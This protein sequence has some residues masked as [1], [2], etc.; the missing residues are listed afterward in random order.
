MVWTRVV[1]EIGMGTDIR[2]T[3]YTKAAVR[4]LKDALWHN[5]LGIGEIVGQDSDAMGAYT[6]ALFDGVETWVEIP[7]ER[8]P[9][10]WH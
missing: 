3:D 9:K 7:P 5:S 8:W 4:A 10:H 6:Q 1:M 2:G